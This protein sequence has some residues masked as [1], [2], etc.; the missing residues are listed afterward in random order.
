MIYGSARPQQFH[1]H[2][3][4]R[5]CPDLI[6]LHSR[7]EFV[8]VHHALEQPPIPIRQ[9]II[10]IQVS[11][12]PAIRQ[13]RQAAVD[14]VDQRNECHVIVPRENPRHDNRRRGR[15]LLNHTQDRLQSSRHIVSFRVASTRGQQ[16]VKVVRP[17]K[18][19]NHFGIDSV[20]LTVF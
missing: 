9:H 18:Q 6:R 19:N 17:G 10:N 1:K 15:L 3:L 16:V 7:M 14:T 5:I 12:L 13:L 8:C 2:R 4:Q 20:Q 11:N